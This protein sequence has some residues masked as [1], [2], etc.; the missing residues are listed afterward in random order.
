MQKRLLALAGLGVVALA[1]GGAAV[2]GA[3]PGQADNGLG[4]ASENVGI[5]LPASRE[6]HPTRESHPGGAPELTA[7]T[8]EAVTAELPEAASFGQS[9]AADAQAGVPQEDG[10]AFG[11]QVSTV[12]REAHQ[13][14]V[15]T[16]DDNPGTEHREAGADN[17]PDEIPTADD[18]P[19][20]A[21]R[22]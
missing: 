2:A 20:T 22:P 18:N 3:L 17:A 14:D 6:N 12:A 7:E 15:P 4:P 9:V 16:A 11:G 19:G 21:H 8:S 13:P 5:E 1:A 10:R